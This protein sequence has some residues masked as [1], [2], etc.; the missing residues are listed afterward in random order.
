[1]FLDIELITESARTQLLS[2]ELVLFRVLLSLPTRDGSTLYS[3]L[4]KEKL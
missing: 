1:M 2:L 4:S 3:Y